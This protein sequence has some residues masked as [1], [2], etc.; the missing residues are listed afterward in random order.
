MLCCIVLLLTMTGCSEQQTGT[1]SADSSTDLRNA[2]YTLEKVVV[3]SRHNIRSPLSGEGS[4]L[5]SVTTHDWIEWSSDTSELTVRGSVAETAMG[6]YFRLW[7][8]E[9][10]LF[11]ENARP[12]EG[13]VRFYANSKQRTLATAKSF[14][15]G[16]FPVAN[17]DVE[18]HMEYDTMDPVFTPALNFV[19]ES[20]NEA[21]Q[22]QIDAMFRSDEA[23]MSALQADY[24]LI[25]KVVDYKNSPAYQRG[26]CTDLV[27]EDFEVILKEGA[28]PSMAGSLKLGCQIS[29]ALVLQSYEAPDTK[30][31]GFGRSLS[32]A[33]WAQISAVKDIYV[34]ILYTAPLVS[35]NVAHPLLEEIRDE[36]NS[37]HKFAFLCGHDSNIGSVLAALNV[38]PYELPDTPEIVPIGSK[39]TLEVWTRGGERYIAPRLIYAG[40][41]QLRDLDILTM[42]NPPVKVDLAFT[43]LQKNAEGVYK[44]SDFLAKI[45]DALV[46]YDAI[47]EQYG[48]LDAAA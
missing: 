18:S 27:A 33:Q 29:D 30:T 15:A 31:A 14:S 45:Q 9:N 25:E 1:R 4:L 36:L 23:L 37:S 22:A 10:G 32:G 28:E 12:E 20:Y 11:E 26:D 13:E 19:S 8:V 47:L 3:L 21:V 35:V 16:M 24:A 2:G 34:D 44:L 43:G 42:E 40:A 38:A 48:E 41:D 6:Q 39:L 5:G 7:T 46:A 17:I